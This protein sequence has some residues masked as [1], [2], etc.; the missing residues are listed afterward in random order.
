MKA[1]EDGLDA[2]HMGMNFGG[3]QPSMHSSKIDS[4][5]CLGS[6]DGRTLNVGDTQHFVFQPS[7]PPPFY[8]RDMPQYNTPMTP[9]QLQARDQKKEKAAKAREAAFD[10]K[11]TKLMYEKF[12]G[13]NREYVIETVR[14]SDKLK[15]A[16]AAAKRQLKEA[17]KA[18]TGVQ[19]Q[20][21]TIPA[22][23]G[24]PTAMVLT[25]NDAAA[26]EARADE[27]DGQDD[28]DGDAGLI[29]PAAAPTDVDVDDMENEQERKKLQENGY[30]QGYVG[31]TKGLKHVLYERGLWKPCYGERQTKAQ[32][33]EHALNGTTKD[34][35]SKKL[36]A[37]CPDF[38]KEK[39]KL[40]E[41]W[42]AEGHILVPSVKGHPE[43]AGSGIEYTWGLCKRWFR[44][45]NDCV[46]ANLEI[47]V[48]AA[49]DQTTMSN[50]WS[51]ERR[52]RDLMRAYLEINRQVTVGELDQND[53]SYAKIEEVRKF[54]GTTC[55]CH[56]NIFDLE[57]KFLR[58]EEARSRP[59]PTAKPNHI[60]PHCCA[61]YLQSTEYYAHLSKIHGKK[62]TVKAKNSTTAAQVTV[63]APVQA[64]SQ[65]ADAMDI[66][67]TPAAAPSGIETEIGNVVGALASGP[68][69]ALNAAIYIMDTLTGAATWLTGSSGARHRED[70]RRCP[71]DETLDG[72]NCDYS[73]PG[74]TQK[75]RGGHCTVQCRENL[76]ITVTPIILRTEPHIR[77]YLIEY[78]GDAYASIVL[79]TDE[80]NNFHSMIATKWIVTR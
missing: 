36:L 55:R 54:V 67:T 21:K 59:V 35:M 58:A 50:V 60:C 74:L 31:K 37:D 10:K 12:S 34:G 40:Q 32:I 51:F 8:N 75:S 29:L 45:N 25:E 14:T 62:K 17:R 69:S 22:V 9:A 53:I 48:K 65:A 80:D 30:I 66:A 7:D 78:N 33:Q 2:F 72:I 49:I 77:R 42:E 76:P 3:K 71:W 18:I 64:A 73:M 16:K 46:A 68:T 24:N 57:G 27:E 19:L 52:T 28:D 23:A 47:N 41:M 6:E 11:I 56:R 61:Q 15:Q 13:R 20:G 38:D 44:R 79:P 43:L 39:G 63:P 70:F 5:D 26:A 1:K 4:I